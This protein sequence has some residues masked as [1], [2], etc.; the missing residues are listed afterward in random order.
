VVMGD[1]N[2]DGS[3]TARSIELN[4]RMLNSTPAPTK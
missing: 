3:V 1:S 2:S 4:P